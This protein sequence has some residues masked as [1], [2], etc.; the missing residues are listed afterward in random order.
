MNT[1]ISKRAMIIWAILLIVAILI[2][3]IYPLI[4]GNTKEQ[5]ISVTQTEVRDPKPQEV[6]GKPYNEFL[7]VYRYF[8]QIRAGVYNDTGKTY[9]SEKDFA[10]IDTNAIKKQFGAM[11]VIKN[12]PRFWT[13]DEI[14]GYYNGTPKTIAGYEMNQ[15]GILN[16]SLTDLKNR[17]AYS[18]H[19]VNRKT[20]YTFRK[21]EKVYELVSDKNEVYTMQ[22]G[23]REI[24]KSL[25][26]ADL[27]TLGARLKLPK[28]WSY[29]VRT[30]DQDV[31]YQIN[32][33]AYVIQDELND[34]YQKNP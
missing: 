32:G 10:K 2:I 21:G 5:F 11:T 16:L 34:S 23:S 12:G 28:G 29:R 1:G 4:R 14:T 24:D 25:T 8:N 18:I 20:T 6:R 31:T 13:M 3:V 26:I 27:D 7:V 33:T 19:K 15:P 22:S 17:S 30:L 9:I